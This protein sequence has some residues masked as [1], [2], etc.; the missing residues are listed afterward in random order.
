MD[1]YATL[2]LKR[3][4]T[5]DDIKK[6]YRSMA[7]KHHPDR[8][9]DEKRFKEI[10]EAYR[11]LSD[12]QKK[13]IIDMGGDPNAQPGMGGG[14]HNQGPFEFHFGGA[15]FDDI[16]SNFGFGRRPAQRNKTLNI[17]IDITL[18]DVLNGKEINAEIT[19]PGTG[20]KKIVNIAIPPGIEDGQQIR[21]EGMGDNSVA[22]IRPGDLIVNVRISPHP[23]FRREGRDIILDKKVSVWDAM[24]GGNVTVDTLDKKTLNISVPAGTQPDT[25]L[26]CRNEG[27]PGLRNKVRG[28]LLIRIKV[29]IPKNLNIAQIELLTNVRKEMNG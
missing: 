1:Y 17:V 28:N 13:N 26:S 8:G 20:K 21:Y 3:G 18:E 16:F 15:G 9:G 25:M 23:K 12:P 4:A 24:L 2:G 27:L 6:A 10:E 14:F 19:L 29:E 22:G 7:M 5:A 11:F